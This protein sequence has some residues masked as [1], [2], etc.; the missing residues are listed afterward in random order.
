L[1][2]RNCGKPPPACR[3][4]P[5]IAIIDTMAPTSTKR[6]KRSIDSLATAA[7][8]A[9]APSSSGAASASASA[10]AAPPFAAATKR[11]VVTLADDADA[12]LAKCRK[13]RDELRR[14]QA[15][16]TTSIDDEG[17]D[18]A[19]SDL[20]WGIGMGG[21][22]DGKRKGK[23]QQ[24]KGNVMSGAPKA[25]T[26]DDA[27]AEDDTKKTKTQQLSLSELRNMTSAN[28][29]K[30]TIVE[31]VEMNS[32]EVMEGIENVAIHI[33]QQVLAKQGFQLAIPCR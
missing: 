16:Q 9:A 33:A 31:V 8:S 26:V 27:N 3:C 7:T 2:S 20:E 14:K 29:G 18:D 24:Q 19:D 4:R 13:L 21:D 15:L 23:Q 30:K 1:E 17:I 12:V 28:N 10:S 11:R 5:P 32:T 22:G 25:A 6:T